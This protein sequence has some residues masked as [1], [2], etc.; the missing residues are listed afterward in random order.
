MRGE[1][2]SFEFSFTVPVSRGGFDTKLTLQS[3]TYLLNRL[4]QLFAMITS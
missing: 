4:L 1:Q 3:I 2:G